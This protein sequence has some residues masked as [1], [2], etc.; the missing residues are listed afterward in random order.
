STQVFTPFTYIAR[1]RY[2]WASSTASNHVKGN[3]TLQT[4][5]CKSISQ[6][7]FSEALKTQNSTRLFIVTYNCP[8]NVEGADSQYC[9]IFVDARDRQNHISGSRFCVFKATKG[10][11]CIFWF[12]A[13][14]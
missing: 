6:F 4:F 2:K 12:N 8:N 11:N 13:K 14:K 3:F 5:F 7:N 1:D 10:H 9:A